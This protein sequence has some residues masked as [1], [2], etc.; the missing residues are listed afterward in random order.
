[1]SYIIPVWFQV[2]PQSILEQGPGTSSDKVDIKMSDMNDSDTYWKGTNLNCLNRFYP[3]SFEVKDGTID[4]TVCP[5]KDVNVSWDMSFRS[6]MYVI[7][8][9][10][11]VN[12]TWSIAGPNF[13]AM[14]PVPVWIKNTG[15]AITT[16]IF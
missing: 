4:W 5:D 10:E 11:K 1:V 2:T 8:D 16:D 13:Q 12:V 9:A 3:N 15:W 6:N 14:A 7:R